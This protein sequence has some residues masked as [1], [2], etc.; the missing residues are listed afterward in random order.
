MNRGKPTSYLTLSLFTAIVT[1]LHVTV[2]LITSRVGLY[3]V[4]S[5]TRL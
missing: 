4:A 3:W 5:C 2:R 1:L